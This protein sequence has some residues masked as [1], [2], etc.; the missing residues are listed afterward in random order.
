MVVDT[1]HN[2]RV[3]SIVAT[4][5]HMTLVF[6]N[7]QTDEV[8]WSE[9]KIFDPS[10]EVINPEQLLSRLVHAITDSIQKIPIDNRRT[11]P[12][13]IHLGFPWVWTEFWKRS[14]ECTGIELFSDTHAY[15][16]MEA[17]YADA[18]MHPS[19]MVTGLM[20]DVSLHQITA[21][22]ITSRGFPVSTGTAMRGYEMSGARIWV[23]AVAIQ[24]LR[25]AILHVGCVGHIQF[26]SADRQILAGWHAMRDNAQLPR[27]VYA[28]QV[29]PGIVGCVEYVSNLGETIAIRN[30]PPPID[31]LTG[32][33]G[34]R[35]LAH[36][37]QQSIREPGGA[38]HIMISPPPDGRDSMWTKIVE[39]TAQQL[40]D[41]LPNH[42]I[43]SELYIHIERNLLSLTGTPMNV[44]TPLDAYVT[45]YT[46]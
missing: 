42:T 23:S 11:V 7:N 12:I 35:M 21:E 28:I 39:Q 24:K 15:R 10:Q 45:T 5:T 8:Y 38:V 25:I 36:Y 29:I 44:Y 30:I 33:G 32:R 13:T 22:H 34:S 31:E 46:N 17:E 1:H 40:S 26:S 6:G 18:V 16:L 2:Y 43:M 3:C 27:D 41:T 9:T 14:Y 37:I 4:T 19:A 20:G